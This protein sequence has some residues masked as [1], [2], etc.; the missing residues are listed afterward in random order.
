MRI[1][2]QDGFTLIEILVAITIFA[3]AVL[4]LAIGTVS[5][6]QTNQNSHLNTSAINLAQAKFEELRAMTSAAFA[7]L[8]C[9]SYAS[10]GCSDSPVASGKTFNRSWQ[11][12]ANS[13]V[14]G[15]NQIDVKVDWTDYISHSLTFTASVP[16]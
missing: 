4:G 15:V 5:L 2:K 7:G 3:F 16:Q 8:S 14:T 13:P 12:T 9:P 1:S 10:T 6:I 11:F